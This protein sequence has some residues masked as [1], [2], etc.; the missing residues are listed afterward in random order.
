M[1]SCAASHALLRCVPCVVMRSLVSSSHDLTSPHPTPHYFS[2]LKELVVF[3]YVYFLHK[4]SSCFSIDLSKHKL[5]YLIQTGPRKASKRKKVNTVDPYYPGKIEKKDDGRP[6]TGIV[7]LTYSSFL[8]FSSS[9]CPSSSL[10]LLS[11]LITTIHELDPQELRLVRHVHPLPFTPPTLQE[12]PT[13]HDPYNVTTAQSSLALALILL[14]L[15]FMLYLFSVPS[16]SSRSP[17]Y[18][19]LIFRL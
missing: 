9:S 15:F 3:G 7:P 19:L 16:L 1:R 13:K 17:S 8:R 14:Y 11:P 12:I 2:C 5:S 10:L 4:I 18:L 6:I